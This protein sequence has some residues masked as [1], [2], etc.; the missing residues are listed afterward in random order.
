MTEKADQRYDTRYEVHRSRFP[1]K[2]GAIKAP[3]VAS[4]LGLDRARLAALGWALEGQSMIDECFTGIVSIYKVGGFNG[5]RSAA[6]LVDV[7]DE[8]VAFRVLNELALPRPEDLTVSIERMQV[9]V[10]RLKHLGF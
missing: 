6:E 10:D 2:G 5:R 9:E 3:F 1:G 4:Y 8:R 7:I